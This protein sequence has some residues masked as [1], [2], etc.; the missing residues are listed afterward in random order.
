[1]RLHVR[2]VKMFSP[3]KLVVLEVLRSKTTF[4]GKIGDKLAHAV[5]NCPKCKSYDW[6]F[7]IQQKENPIVTLIVTPNYFMDEQQIADLS[8]DRK[9]MK[10][11]F[12]VSGKDLARQLT[13][14]WQ[15]PV[16]YAVDEIF[17]LPQSWVN[18]IQGG[19]EESLFVV[20]FNMKKDMI[21]KNSGKPRKIRQIYV[22]PYLS[23]DG[24]NMLTAIRGSTE[25]SV[26]DAL[27]G[28]IGTFV[29]AF[30]FLVMQGILPHPNQDGQLVGTIIKETIGESFFQA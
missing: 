7:F 6:K 4:Y 20:Q 29:Q 2:T 21:A 17:K 3:K 23:E 13:L 15:G 25:Q 19:Y 18:D 9:I 5:I 27:K 28:R 1:M 30:Y 22:I 26:V 12:I 11:N 8:E 14:G 16:T 10:H 24:N